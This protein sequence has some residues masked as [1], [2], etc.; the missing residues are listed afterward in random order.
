VGRPPELLRYAQSRDT[1][2][3]PLLPG[4]L[5]V[6]VALWSSS[7]TPIR[8]PR[9]IA[10]HGVTF[11]EAATIF[12]DPQAL[13]FADPDHSGDGDRFLTWVTPPRGTCSSFPNT[14]R[15]DRTRIISARRATRKERRL[16]EQG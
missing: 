10:K 2:A 6:T 8:P 16:Y 1:Q 5:R 4:P 13:T 14:D 11:G 9:N 3:A 12:G 7:G 15:G